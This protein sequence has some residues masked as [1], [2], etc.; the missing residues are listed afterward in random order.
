VTPIIGGPTDADSDYE[1]SAL[2]DSD[3]AHVAVEAC[4]GWEW[5]AD[6]LEQTGYDVHLA[7]QKHRNTL[8]PATS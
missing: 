3:D 7:Q 1:E 6:P 4:Y 5:L 2:G 8:F